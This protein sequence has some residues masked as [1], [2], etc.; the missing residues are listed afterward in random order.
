MVWPAS[1]FFLRS[2]TLTKLCTFR[3]NRTGPLGEKRQIVIDKHEVAF[4]VNSS[5]PQKPAHWPS[6][7]AA[8][9]RLPVIAKFWLHDRTPWIRLLK[10]WVGPE[11]LWS[12]KSPVM[13][14]PAPDVAALLLCRSSVCPIV[15]PRHEV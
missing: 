5:L 2:I 6:F 15:L 7:C 8:E 13:E 1:W 4:I 3:L 12:C 14:L 10:T 11:L 9:F